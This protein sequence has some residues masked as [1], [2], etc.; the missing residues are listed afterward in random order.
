ML[1]GRALHEIQRK[2][3]LCMQAGHAGKQ[4]QGPPLKLAEVH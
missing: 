4:V 2:T 1:G 3:R